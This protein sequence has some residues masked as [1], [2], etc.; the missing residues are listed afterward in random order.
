MSQVKKYF[1]EVLSHKT[2]GAMG[3]KLP[4]FTKE[5]AKKLKDRI[6]NIKLYLHSYTLYKNFLYGKLTIKEF[7][8]F[9]Y[10]HG[11]EG[12]AIN[13]RT[14]KEGS[15]NFKTDDEIKEIAKY[16]EFLNLRINIDISSTNKE[17]FKKAL[18]VANLVNA[19]AIRFY[20]RKSGLVSKIIRE[21]VP[22]LKEMAKLAK[23]S[24]IE[25][26]MEQHEDLKSYELVE[27]VKKVNAQNLNLM[28][29]Y[30]NMINAYEKPLE[31]L[32][33]MA[34]LVKHVH[35]KGVKILKEGKG[36]GHIGV[37]EGD[38]DL[39]HAKLMFDLLML[40]DKEPQIEI[41][42]LEEVNDYYAPA[43][44]FKDEGND[45]FISKRTVSI[46][47]R[48]ENVCLEDMLR[49]ERRDAFSQVVFIQSLLSELKTLANVTI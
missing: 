39:P 41:F 36:F 17:E 42:Y 11:F 16:A 47:K 22:V 8:D 15:F 7:L 45:A 49:D 10:T 1:A 2:D 33:I 24:N 3:I 48:D 38:D 23:K 34:P 37:R 9:A 31:A 14:G 6:L 21:I 18:H 5:V 20:I 28:F 40:G 46:T 26:L 43:Y 4:L 13:I 12:I 25:L 19:K 27:I 29:D 32:Q 35:I 30:G 44:R